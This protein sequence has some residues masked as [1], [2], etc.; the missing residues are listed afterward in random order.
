MEIAV[1]YAFAW[2]V[3]KARRVAGR[4]DTEVDRGLD[5]GM[6]RLHELISGKLGEDPALERAREE[7]EAGSQEP[8]QRTRQ[9]L[10][11]AL[12]DAAER[13]PDFAQALEEL[14][15]QLQMTNGAGGVSAS[16]D[17]QAVGGSVDIRA[18]HGAAAALRMG[19]VTIEASGNPPQPGPEQG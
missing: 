14:V 6:D 17:G 19:D 18:E 13:D 5:A 3:G 1:G 8:S 12:E 15:R 7:A 16:G 10:E 2:L 11:L 4:A 9:R